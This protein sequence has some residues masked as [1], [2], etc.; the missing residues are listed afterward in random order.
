MTTSP[1]RKT[2]P[3]DKICVI[4]MSGVNSFDSQGM[5]QF[6]QAL[7]RFIDTEQPA[8][9]ILDFAG[10]RF[11]SARMI[12]DLLKAKRQLLRTNG[13]LRLSGMSEAL[14]GCFRLLNLDGKVFDIGDE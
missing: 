10:V 12:G 2:P 14:R 3:A 5:G 1:H 6:E 13:R 4:R 11:C 7:R 9:L 8:E